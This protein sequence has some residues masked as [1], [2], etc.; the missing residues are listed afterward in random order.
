MGLL[1][2]FKRLT[3]KRRCQEL[4]K[5]MMT[6]IPMPTK[7]YGDDAGDKYYRKK[8][9]RSSLKENLGFYRF[10]ED[11]YQSRHVSVYWPLINRSTSYLMELSKSALKLDLLHP[12]K[13]MGI[14]V[15]QR[16]AECEI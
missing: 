16:W 12:V 2:M 7:N 13:R 14:C 5:K 11:S 8:G 4:L 3:T 6:M 9:G 1:A 10:S 15:E